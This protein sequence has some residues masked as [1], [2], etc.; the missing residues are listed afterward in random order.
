MRQPSASADASSS[1]RCRS[2]QASSRRSRFTTGAAPRSPDP[3]EFVVTAEM[4]WHV[5]PSRA[6]GGNT[7]NAGGFSNLE[8]QRVLVTRAGLGPLQR[9]VG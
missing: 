7:F 4:S 3:S 6:F 1:G 9:R 2:S 8:Q 5:D